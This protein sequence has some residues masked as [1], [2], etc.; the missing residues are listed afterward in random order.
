VGRPEYDS[1][2]LHV[3]GVDVQREIDGRAGAT[4][5]WQVGCWTIANQ[6]VAGLKHSFYHVLLSIAARLEVTRGSPPGVSE[7][8]P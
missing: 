4:L 6:A 8:V 2:G 5:E 3:R 7:I 1:I